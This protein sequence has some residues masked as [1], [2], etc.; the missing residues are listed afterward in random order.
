VTVD[1]RISNTGTIVI[2]SGGNG[3][4]SLT[5]AGTVTTSG[6]LIVGVAVGEA[7][8]S[9]ET[10]LVAPDVHVTGGILEGAGTVTG[11]V[12]NTGGTVMAYPATHF[13]LADRLNVDGNYNQGAS[14]ILQT[15]AIEGPSGA[16]LTS[17]NMS[18]SI[19]L[20]GGTLLVDA[21]TSL[22]LNTPYT[23]ATFAPG[24]L[25]GKF[26]HVE[27]E[28]VLGDH[29]GNGTSVSLGNGDTLEVLYNNA[30]GTIQIEEVDPPASSASTSVSSSLAGIA[31]TSSN[32]G[33]LSAASQSGQ[34]AHALLAQ[35][36]ASSFALGGVDHGGAVV[37]PPAVATPPLVASP[38]SLRHS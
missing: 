36:A 21:Q 38:H 30:A 11:T 24:D 8:V 3:E 35:Y 33:G 17:V 10:R 31:Q 23:V 15:D 22:A 2:A 26:S 7:G 13:G 20:S 34:T 25:T 4:E 18:G 37:S 12:N 9:I 28:G 19:H 1:G 14:G 27:T 6:T 16:T 32:A 29:T 5:S